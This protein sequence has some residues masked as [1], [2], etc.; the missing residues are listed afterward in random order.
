LSC[1]NLHVIFMLNRCTN[2]AKPEYAVLAR[3]LYSACKLCPHGPIM[4]NQ[5]WT[6]PD[7]RHVKQIT[8]YTS[9]VPGYPMMR[10]LASLP[11]VLMTMHASHGMLQNHKRKLTYHLRISIDLALLS[12]CLSGPS[13]LSLRSPRYSRRASQL[14]YCCGVWRRT[15]AEVDA[16]ILVSQSTKLRQ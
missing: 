6:D 7:I 4:Q 1:V 3:L 8:V 9:I 13:K 15:G 16:V 10:N 12:T 14:V 11:S 5:R 2:D